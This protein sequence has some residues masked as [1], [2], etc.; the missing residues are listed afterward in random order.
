MR[1]WYEE[2][3]AEI[4]AEARGEEFARRQAF[5]LA[6]VRP[7]V[8][9]LDLG[10]GSGAFAAAAR[11]AGAEVVGVDIA[12]GALDRAAALDPELDLRLAPPH[13]PLPLADG[14]VELVWA[15]EVIEHVADTAGWLSEVRRVLAPRGRLLLTTPF[16]GRLSLAV[17]ALT[18]PERRFD[19][20]GQHLRFYTRRSLAGLLA[21]FGFDEIDVRPAGGPPG[22]R[23]LLLARARRAGL[24]G[25]R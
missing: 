19:P 25:R 12:Q 7:G 24:A 20:Q 17:A 21:E 6:E 1:D 4:P 2:V 14:A 18:G 11:A 5:L 10:C 15:S 3:W 8:R 16:H 23:R 13:G 22:L 9:L